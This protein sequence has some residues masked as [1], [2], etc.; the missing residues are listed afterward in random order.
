[1]KIFRNREFAIESAIILILTAVFTVI[2]AFI[3]PLGALFTAG[4]GGCVYALFYLSSKRR[5]NRM[6]KLTDDIDKILHGNRDIKI[7]DN[8]EG[9]LSVLQNELSKMLI[10]LNEQNDTLKNE[11][12]F[13]SDSIADISHQLRTPLTS[14]NLILSL[15]HEPDLTE[16]KRLELLQKL[17]QLIARTDYLI[18]VLLKMSKID[19][20]T[21]TFEKQPIKV[22][23]LVTKAVEPL[24]VALE[25]K[26]QT[27]KTQINDESFIGDLPWTIEAFGNIIKNCHEHT[28]QGGTIQITAQ[29]TPI[30]T[31]ITVNDSGNGIDQDDLPH[32]FERF[33]KGKNSSD[34]SFGIG[35]ALAQTII[36]GQNGTI[37]ASNGKNGGAQFTVR[38]Y[39]QTV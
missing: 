29:S 30:Y 23:T 36:I 9:E 5:Y 35:L 38:F 27:I 26:G 18:N 11:K 10:I 22:K 7:D 32:I 1:M 8:L 15:L 17:S 28:P 19:A 21:V 3:R 12:K 37:K 33:Y 6:E 13:L 25:L 34:N 4:L 24:E 14:I 16:E 20:G 31:Q 2:T 39:K